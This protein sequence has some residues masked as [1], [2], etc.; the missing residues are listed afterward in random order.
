MKTSKKV[1][2]ATMMTPWVVNPAQ[3]QP[4]T[5][6]RPARQPNLA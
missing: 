3:D 5:R 4:I 2:C 1:K 6:T